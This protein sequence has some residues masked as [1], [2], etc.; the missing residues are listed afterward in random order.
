MFGMQCLKGNF[1]TLYYNMRE[2]ENRI[3]PTGSYPPLQLNWYI[4]MTL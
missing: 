2:G 3:P 4:G 1:Q